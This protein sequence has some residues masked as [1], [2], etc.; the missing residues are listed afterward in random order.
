MTQK[1][2][3]CRDAEKIT[4]PVNTTGREWQRKGGIGEG[5]KGGKRE[6]TSRINTQTTSTKDE[7][8]TY[9]QA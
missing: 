2:S 1:K 9:M 3:V 8:G 4:R 6:M 7:V 5:D